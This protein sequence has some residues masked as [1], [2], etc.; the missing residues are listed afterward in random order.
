MI[1][2]V[3]VAFASRYGSVNAE[4]R[5]AP[6][7]CVQGWRVTGAASGQHLKLAKDG[8]EESEYVSSTIKGVGKSFD[9]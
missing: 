4:A 6:A 8:I 3:K 9:K 5:E 2:G 1:V 7:K